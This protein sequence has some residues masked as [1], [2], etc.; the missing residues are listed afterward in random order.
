MK[1]SKKNKIVVIAIIVL[2][3]VFVTLLWQQSRLPFQYKTVSEYSDQNYA[4]SC[5]QP[6]KVK[7]SYGYIPGPEGS[8]RIPVY[9]PINQEEASRYC[10]ITGA[11]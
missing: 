5:S 4:F 3:L 1:V 7:S 10:H 2:S 6:I 9:H 11:F 8:R